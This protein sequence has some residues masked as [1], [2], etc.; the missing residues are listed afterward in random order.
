MYLYS[1]IFVNLLEFHLNANL[2]FFSNTPLISASKWEG[3]DL[4][5]FPKLSFI[6]GEKKK[7]TN[8]WEMSSR[9]AR[10]SFSFS[11]QKLPWLVHSQVFLFNFC[12]GR[13]SR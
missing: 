13:G 1:L 9:T 8:F 10:E 12:E 2:T 11:I 4:E 3:S 7:S 6:F 5:T